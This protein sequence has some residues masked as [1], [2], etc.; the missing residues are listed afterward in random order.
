METLSCQR[1]IFESWYTAR[2]GPDKAVVVMLLPELAI[3]CQDLVFMRE[4]ALL[5]LGI[6]T[7]ER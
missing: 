1:Y 2:P 5:A 6:A 4:S 7:S 3:S